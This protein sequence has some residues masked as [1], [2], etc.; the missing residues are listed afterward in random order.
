MRGWILYRDK[1]EELKEIPYEMKRF[2]EVAAQMGIE[3]SI[4][5]PEQ[6]DLM[7]SRDDH[8]SILLE[9]R[10]VELPD[11]MLV[12]LGASTTYFGQAVVRQIQSQGVLVLNSSSGIEK[13]MDKL[14][15]QQIL[16]SSGLPVPN[17]ALLKFP[18]NA[19][20]IEK[21]LKFPTVI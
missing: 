5:K 7:V 18:I 13:S 21:K 8:K 3:L 20:L 11:F 14:Y 16:T 9:G 4:Y 10:P 15:A 12:R 19:E 6:F 2:T 17:T 1:L